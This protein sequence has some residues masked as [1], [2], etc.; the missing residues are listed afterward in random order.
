MASGGAALSPELAS[1]LEALGWQVAIGYGLTETS[2]LLTLKLPG[3]AHYDTVGRAVS[4]VEIRI[5]PGVMPD[6]PAEENATGQGEILARGPNVFGGY[7]NLPEKTAEVF[8]RDGWFRTG[9]LGF[10]DPE[11]YLHLT[12]RVSTLIVAGGGEN[13]QPDRIEAHL[14]SHPLIREAGV[15]QI[16]D[17][18]LAAVVVPEIREMKKRG[19][20]DANR[21]AREAAAE[22]SR[23]LPSYQRIND[24]AVTREPIPRTRLGKIRRHLLED[25]FQRAKAE[26]AAPAQAGTGP[27]ALSDMSNQDQNLLE[28]PAAARVW[29]RLADRYRDRRLSPDSSPDLDL[30]IDSM[31]WVNLT[32]EIRR[33]AGVEVEEKDIGEIA[34]VRDLL[35]T[36]V[37][38][39]D[40]DGMVPMESPLEE[41][42][43]KLTRAQMRWLQPTGTLE[44][45]VARGLFA[46]NRWIVERVFRLESRALENLPA[47]GAFLITPNHVSYL[48]AFVVAAAL[49]FPRLQ[50]VY[51]AGFTGAAFRN[52]FFRYFSRLSQTVP[53]DPEKGMISSLAFGAAVLERGWGLVW[54]PEGQRSLDGRI[55]PF[56]TGVGVLLEHHPVP[57]VPAFVRGT[58]R[59]LPPGKVIP[60]PG[61]VAVAFGRPLD[62]GELTRKGKG[63]E[64]RER[65]VSALQEEV[66][67]LGKSVGT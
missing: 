36:V 4:G 29:A 55:Q 39:A 49:G 14:S 42:E 33:D 31:E 5:D 6:S 53:V 1:R 65:I 38:K 40:S 54:F 17:G 48:D 37:E 20:Q 62:P 66:V 59:I 2:P 67:K 50:R 45:L 28:H 19:I 9:D 22:R 43:K 52:P 13:I 24:V 47:E 8:T 56:K 51:W 41:P 25:L 61:S 18:T 34:T 12:G 11:G 21:A 30:G 15:L 35:E 32:L 57:V 64:A 46:G 58:E 10:L 60:R 63:K 16:E 23:G 44:R 7:H 27:V 3:D 26:Q